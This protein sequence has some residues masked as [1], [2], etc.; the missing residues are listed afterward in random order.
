M[1]GGT[2]IKLT[3]WLFYTPFLILTHG[4]IGFRDGDYYLFTDDKI[5]RLRQDIELVNKLEEVEHVVA[6]EFDSQEDFEQA[7]KE[8]PFT[9]ERKVSRFKEITFSRLP[10]ELAHK[11]WAHRYL[12]VEMK[13]AGPSGC[14]CTRQWYSGASE[15]SV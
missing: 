11:L 7:L 10:I 2:S 13:P 9:A 4:G 6:M 5:S 15:T 12:P 14:L 3:G 8:A 1:L